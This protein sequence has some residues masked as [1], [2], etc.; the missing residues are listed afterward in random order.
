MAVVWK[1]PESR[2]NLEPEEP[3]YL[4]ERRLSRDVTLE[5][6]DTREIIKESMQTVSKQLSFRT[7]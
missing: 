1:R 6:T 5:A 7:F 4:G 3:P 2:Q